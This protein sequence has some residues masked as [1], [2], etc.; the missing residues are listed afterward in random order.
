[1]RRRRPVVMIDEGRCNGC[2]QCATACTEGAIEIV[3]GKARLVSESY[4]DGL[5]ACLGECPQGAIAIEEREA[6]AF[7]AE[8]V[9]EHLARRRGQVAEQALA[10]GCPGTASQAL[11]GAAYEAEE[12]GQPAPSRLG[13]W[14]VQLMLVPSDAPYLQGA[15]LVISADC[16][17]VALADFHRRFLGGRALLL[18]C[19]KL[20]D[21]GYYREKLAAILGPNDVESVEVVYMEVPCCFGLVRLVQQAIADSGKTIPLTLAKI[22]IRGE[23]RETASTGAA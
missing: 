12:S 1:M 5:G 6:K 18:G 11:G 19:P 22:G 2:G 23:V 10:C 17:P 7:D 9:E 15:R 21:A 16:V 8:A 3:N 20:D 4:C 14:P 13:N